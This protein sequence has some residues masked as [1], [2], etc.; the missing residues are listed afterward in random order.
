VRSESPKKPRVHVH[1]PYDSFWS[2]EPLIRKHG[3]SV[4]LYFGSNTVDEIS[5]HDLREIAAAMDWEHTLSIH[6]PFMDLSPGAI[7]PKIAAASLE[8]YIQMIEF[9]EIL[10]TEVLV[11]HS[12]YEKWKYAGKVEL[13]LEPS[14]RTWRAV[15]ER[16]DAS[17]VKV[18]IENIVDSEP[19]HLKRLAQEV[20]H[21]HFGLCLDV[22]HRE[23][24]SSLKIADWVTG[25]HPHILEMHLHDNG[26]AGD[27][28]SPIGE[29]RVDFDSLFKKV[30]ELGLDPV[31]TL[32]A[33]SAEEALRSLAALGQY[34]KH[35]G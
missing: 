15:M 8:R 1:V 33:H 2:Y 26:G 25:M 20:G 24:F 35:G 22:G 30:D 21:P 29:G 28:H 34:L 32:E 5:E 17:G 14:I 12:G 31:Y 27:D 3:L 23:I 13:W 9:S 18:A 4:E 16:A 10:R 6:G 19:Y 11:F 7:D